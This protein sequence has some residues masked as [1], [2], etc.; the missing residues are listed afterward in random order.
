MTNIGGDPSSVIWLASYSDTRKV[1]D[2]KSNHR[3]SISF[4]ASDGG[5]WMLMGTA[6]IA[7][8]EEV[9]KKWRFWPEVLSSK[10][11]SSS[12][13]PIGDSSFADHRRVILFRATNST[14]IST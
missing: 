1:A 8:D 12:E 4:Q 13:R 9:E 11:L 2:I 7:P 14:R 6:E 10:P 3:A 5:A